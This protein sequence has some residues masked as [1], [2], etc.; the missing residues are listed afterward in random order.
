MLLI[1]WLAARWQ[2]SQS[3]VGVTF[4]A[5]DLD[6]GISMAAGTKML[7]IFVTHNFFVRVGRVVAI[8]TTDQAVFFAALTVQ[9]SF[10]ALM[11]QVFHVI[12]PHHRHR[13]DTVGRNKRDTP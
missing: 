6:T 5:V 9:Y 10:I 4:E 11:Q 1:L 7:R 13:F 12:A 3:P 2:H 8:D